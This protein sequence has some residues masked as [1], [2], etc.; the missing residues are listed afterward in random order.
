MAIY[1]QKYT[2]HFETEGIQNRDE[3]GPDRIL[4]FL[5]GSEPNWV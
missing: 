5:A 1:V 4:T 2:T 3:H